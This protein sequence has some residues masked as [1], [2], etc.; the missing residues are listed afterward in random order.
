MVWVFPTRRVSLS[1]AMPLSQLMI[2][3]TYCVLR[4]RL[5]FSGRSWPVER[6]S[7]G[8]PHEEGLV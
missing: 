4:R 7:Q 3:V 2:F 5:G 6:S 1:A 8:F